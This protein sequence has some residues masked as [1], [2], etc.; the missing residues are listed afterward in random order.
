LLDC[1][2]DPEKVR[3]R[4]RH[5]FEQARAGLAKRHADRLGFNDGQ[6][7]ALERLRRIGCDDLD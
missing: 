2:D 3:L 4:H 6:E 7:L 1:D 5:P